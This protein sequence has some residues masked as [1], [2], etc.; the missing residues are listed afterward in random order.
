MTEQENVSAGAAANLAGSTGSVPAAAAAAGQ[1]QNV[2]WEKQYKELEVK[3]GQQGRELGEYREFITN[4]APLLD[5]LEKGPE[6]VEAILAGKVD[7]NLAKAAIEGRLTVNEAVAAGA[8]VNEVKN[9][10]GAAAFQAASPDEI[11]KLVD[12]KVS[13]KL[14]ELEEKDELR[15]FQRKT[16]EFMQS[17]PDFVKY[18][19][20]ID[21]WLDAHPAITDIDVAYH[22]VKG[23]LSV[24]E[25]KK[26]ADESAA[27][28]AKNVILNA[29]PGGV[30]AQFTPDGTPLVDKLISGRADANRFF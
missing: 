27:E 20:D 30:Q 19:D 15:E 25:A 1:T 12:A 21:A 29:G 13:E 24:A 7:T 28:N 8:A 16:E 23:E 5:K 18:A 6:L 2:D 22:A 17:T 9:E 26:A 14:R 3:F 4:T 10:L 11:G